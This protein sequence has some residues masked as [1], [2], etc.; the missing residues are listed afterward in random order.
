MFKL[1]GTLSTLTYKWQRSYEYTH[2]QL[3]P[4]IAPPQ[5]R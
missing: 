1:T 4:C 5:K 3:T 2:M